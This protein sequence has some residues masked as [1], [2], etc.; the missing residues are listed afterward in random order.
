MKI[1]CPS[2]LEIPVSW[3][4]SSQGVTSQN[5]RR[6]ESF[7]SQRG[8]TQAQYPPHPTNQLVDNLSRT[9]CMV[10]QTEALKL[11]DP[12]YDTIKPHEGKYETL[13]SGMTKKDAAASEYEEAKFVKKTM[14]EPFDP[15]KGTVENPYELDLPKP[16][17]PPK[18]TVENPYELDPSM[19]SALIPKDEP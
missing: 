14:P 12:L 11:Q 1:P 2:T 13:S 17:D 3:V 4:S 16:F 9:L 15:P 18:G 7:L 5:R 8:R 6:R 19:D 10:L